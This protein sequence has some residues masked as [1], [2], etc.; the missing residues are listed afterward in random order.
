[1]FHLILMALDIAGFCVIQNSHAFPCHVIQTVFKMLWIVFRPVATFQ[2]IQNILIS[3]AYIVSVV[4][5]K[6][7]DMNLIAIPKASAYN[8]FILV[9]FVYGS[10]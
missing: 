8:N 6:K 4:I 9:C 7:I 3:I 2:A 1:M 10:R 5:L